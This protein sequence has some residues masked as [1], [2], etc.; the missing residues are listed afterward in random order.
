MD[1]V[2]AWED[3][4]VLEMENGNGFTTVCMY[5]TPLNRAFKNG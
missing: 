2:L 3:E 5:L 4:T 1:T